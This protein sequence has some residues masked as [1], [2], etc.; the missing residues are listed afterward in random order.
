MK[1][2]Y[3][4]SKMIRSGVFMALVLIRPAACGAT[5]EIVRDEEM[6]T[7]QT[8][9]RKIREI[10]K[11]GDFTSI[12]LRSGKSSFRIP[13]P[14]MDRHAAMPWYPWILR[15]SGELIEIKSVEFKQNGNFFYA[16]VECSAQ[17][18]GN[19]N[20]I[21]L[22]IKK[23]AEL[24]APQADVCLILICRPDDSLLRI[25]D[26]IEESDNFVEGRILFLDAGKR[27]V[28]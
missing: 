20:E 10:A 8:F 28:E 6:A 24:K 13:I 26:L 22:K 19:A 27:S 14:L 7:Y 25:C 16:V 3:I 4:F 1:K 9:S 11:S 18:A 12:V 15:Q 23:E 5:N 17:E 21:S 2:L